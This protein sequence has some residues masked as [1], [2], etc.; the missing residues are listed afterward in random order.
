[1]SSMSNTF[2]MICL[3]FI[4]IFVPPLGVFLIAGCGVDF[5]INVLLTCLGYF[6]GH[7]HAFYVEYVYYQR[8]NRDPLTRASQRPAPGV[9][10]DRVQNGGYNPA[11]A[12]QTYGTI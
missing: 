10:S 4:T 2:D 12:G 3:I 1:M 7:I 9:Y 11:P 6:P 8:Q 5:W